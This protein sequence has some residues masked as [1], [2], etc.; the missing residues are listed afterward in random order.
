MRGCVCGNARYPGFQSV[1]LVP[2]RTGIG[3]VQYDTA[4]QSDMAKTALDGFQ[5]AP[6]LMMKVG[7]ARRG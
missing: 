6:G 3:F 1:R 5:I 4:T 7:F 2:G